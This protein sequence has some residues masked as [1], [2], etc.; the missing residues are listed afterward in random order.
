MAAISTVE[1]EIFY[2]LQLVVFSVVAAVGFVSGLALTL[3]RAWGRRVIEVL[4]WLGLL[5]YSGTALILAFYI[6]RIFWNGADADGLMMTGAVMAIG[7]TGAPFF[8]MARALR[9]D[10]VSQE[11]DHA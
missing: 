9:R 8:Y 6:P 1:S 3:G 5:Y 7:A 10:S 11:V 2:R 4:S